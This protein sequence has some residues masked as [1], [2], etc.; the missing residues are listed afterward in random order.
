MGNACCHSTQNLLSSILMYVPCTV[1]NLLFRPTNVLYIN[2]NVYFVKYS[3]MF[4][5][6]Y[7]IFR[8]ILCFVDRASRYIHSKKTQLYAQFIFSTFRQTPLHVSGISIAHQQE[9]HHIDTTVGTYCSF[10]KPA[11]TTDSHIKK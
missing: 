6:I 10:W 5:C 4:R 2:S 1:R 11:R 3:D 9:V 8:E 7:I